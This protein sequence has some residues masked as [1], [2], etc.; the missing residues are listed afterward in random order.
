MKRPGLSAFINRMR[1]SYDIH[2]FGD[3]ESGHI[4]EI[5]EALDPEG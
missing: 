4:M 1:R 3:Q 5:A 2:L